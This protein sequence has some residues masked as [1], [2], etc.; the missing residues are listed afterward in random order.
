MA[1]ERAPAPAESVEPPPPPLDEEEAFSEESSLARRISLPEGRSL[2][3]HTARGVLINSFFDIG[4]TVLGFVRRVG[5]AAF[6]TQTEYGLWGLIVTTLITLSWLKQI[7]ISD[8]YVQQDD[9]DEEHAFQKAFTLEMLYSLLTYGLILVALPLYAAIYGEKSIILPGAIAAL[10]LVAAGFQTPIWIAYRRMQFVRQRT[11]ESIDPVVTLIVTFGLGIAGYGYWS[12]VWGGLAGSVSSAIAA[13]ATSP[14]KLAFRYDRGTLSEYFS[15]SWPLFVSAVSGLA[16]VQGTIIVGNFSVG[17]A[18]VGL[19]GLAGSF[20]LFADRVDAIVRQTIYPAVCA[21]RDRRHLFFEAFV[22]SNRI[23]VLFGLTFGLGLALFGPDLVTYVLGERWRNA[24]GLLQALGLIVGFRQIAYNWTTF[25]RA[26]GETRPIA[27]GSAI[28]VASFL[29]ITAPL[30]LVL[31]VT[32]YAIGIGVSVVLDL[33]ART[34]FLSKLFPGEGVLT[35]MYRS[36]LPSVPAVA[37]VGAIRLLET[38]PRTLGMV[39]LEIVV[40]LGVTAAA[41][42]KFERPLLTEVVGYLKGGG[43]VRQAT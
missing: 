9:P 2:R 18:G 37:A 26:D 24:A 11:L 23:G 8:K 12:L 17:L 3:T 21:V 19:I 38:G 15:F 43:L 31:G 32:G 1:T 36:L 22:K 42:F 16:V 29:L 14:F 4:L 6:L 13:T 27:I 20:T 5:I 35:Y 39:A 41:T 7:G 30:I 10:A 34:Y 40:Y 28:Q 25:I 33:C